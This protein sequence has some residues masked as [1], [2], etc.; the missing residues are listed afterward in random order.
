MDEQGTIDWIKFAKIRGFAALPEQQSQPTPE[1]FTRSFPFLCETAAVTSCSPTAV[2]VLRTR[3]RRSAEEAA[4]RPALEKRLGKNRETVRFETRTIAGVAADLL[5]SIGKPVHKDELFRLI[6]KRRP[7]AR[8][9]MSNVLM[10]DPRF[11]RT[12]RGTWNV[13]R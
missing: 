8:I 3:L 9:S 1:E 7:L 4:P 5:L 10:Q 6:E 12:G 2:A 11:V 13:S